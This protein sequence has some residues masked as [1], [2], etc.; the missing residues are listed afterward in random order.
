[1]MSNVLK[2][3]AK[4]FLAITVVFTVFSYLLAIVLG[5]VLVYFTPEGLNATMMHLPFLPIWFLYV[6][7]YI[8]VGVD[9]GIVFLGLWIIF[10]SS[11]IAAWKVRESFLKTIK[12]S[13][14]QP[15]RKLF[16]SSLFALPVINS[17]TLIAVVTI[18]SLQEARGIPTGMPPLQGEPFIDFFDLSYSAV[19]EE[20]GFR[21]IPI[22]VF[23]ILYLFIIK[24]VTVTFSLKQKAKLFFMSFLFPDRARRMA[25]AKT[26]SE[27]GIWRGISVGEWGILVFVSL[28]FGLAHFSPGGSWEVGKI[29]SAAVSGLVIGSSYLVYGAHASIIMHWFFNVYT[30]TY[31]LLARF[32]PVTAPFANITVI[33]SIILGIF[34]WTLLAIY[35]C[36]KL[37]KSIK[38]QANSG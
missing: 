13:I 34:G 21:F 6:S 19:V 12:E 22:G 11:F 5:P 30:E 24:K 18:N 7:V 29:S 8:P 25:G 3:F 20:V 23:L 1:M 14:V 2:L 17:M 26:V 35:G 28:V 38:K 9:L 4:M 33:V 36:F 10:T 32:Y 27:H 31:L 16:S 15:T 37:V